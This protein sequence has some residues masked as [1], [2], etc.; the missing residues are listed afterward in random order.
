MNERRK[1]NHIVFSSVSRV[2]YLSNED[3]VGGDESLTVPQLLFDLK[4][5]TTIL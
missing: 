1:K 5:P 4:N 3:T 2:L